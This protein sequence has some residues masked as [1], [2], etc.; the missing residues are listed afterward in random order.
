MAGA[1]PMD[2]RAAIRKRAI[3]LEVGGFRPPDDP[4][5]SWFGRVT[6]AG[7]DEAWPT[8]N[9]AP[10]HALC[11]INLA[12][13]PFRPPRLADLQMITVFVG[14]DDLPSDGPNGDNWCLRAYR[15]LSELLPIEPPATGS[16]IR[17]FPMRPRVVE[18]DFPCR[19][20]VPLDLPDDVDEEYDDLYENVP[21]IKLGGW[22]TLLQSEIFWAPWNKHP[23]APEFVFQ[24]DSSEKTGWS[25]G[26][27]GV[28]YFGRG[29]VAGHEHEWA[30]A[31][32]SL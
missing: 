27:G 13:L 14:P 2:I 23:A 22:P 29:T 30:L 16:T 9:G 7:R 18:E 28:G 15:D 26:D 25:W 10:M 3:V 1:I 6:V 17:A 12:E 19:D 11:Q 21:G 8:M 32:Q 24:I 20:D 31:W 5:A 4:M